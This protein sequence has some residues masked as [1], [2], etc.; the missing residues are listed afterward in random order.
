MSSKSDKEKTKEELIAELE[1]LRKK[2]EERTK[3]TALSTRRRIAK[4]T[5]LKK[6]TDEE[7]EQLKREEDYSLIYESK[8]P[9]LE[10]QKK[11]VLQPHQKKI[12]EAFILSSIRSGVL[13]HG[14]GT[15]KTFSAVGLIKAYLQLYPHHKVILITPPALLFG[16]VDSLI[17]YGINPQDTR[18]EYYSYTSFVNYKVDTTNSL[19]IIDEAHNLRTEIVLT[20]DKNK[21]EYPDFLCYTLV[22]N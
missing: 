6:L 10:G 22:L 8:T 11:I 19:M 21:N 15:G 7:L 16:F 12:I 13:F 14:V 5:G 17:A 9:L 1:A 2:V 20:E 3:K 4:K 18:F